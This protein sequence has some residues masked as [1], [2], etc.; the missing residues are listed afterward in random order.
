MK[1]IFNI[2][3]DF[4]I[5]N[6]FLEYYAA[7]GVTKFICGL[8]KRATSQHVDDIAQ[9]LSRYGHEICFSYSEDFNGERDAEAQNRMRL[10]LLDPKEW[11]LI[12]DPDEFHFHHMFK[13]FNEMQLTAEREG[14]AYVGS[15]LVDR[16]PASG[17]FANL[18]PRLSLDDQFPLAA[19]LTEKLTGGCGWKVVMAHS[20]VC[21]RPGHHFADGMR[22]S[23]LCSTHHFKWQGLHLPQLMQERVKNYWSQ[24]L[25]YWV[26][27]QRF[28]TYFEG[29]GRRIDMQ[30]ASLGI[31]A[32][33]RIGV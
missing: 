14:A 1:L 5:L 28:M 7:R 18:N 16:L 4:G 2:I 13:T 30:D 15:L 24:G 9:K 27:P 6:H 20:S 26:E 23:F 21:I 19:R 8:H 12:A 33:E 11:Y 17:E 31:M 22:A 32:S 29:K 25:S 3:E 10:Q